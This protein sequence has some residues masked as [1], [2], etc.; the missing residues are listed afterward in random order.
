MNKPF[1]TLREAAEMWGYSEEYFQRIWPSLREK[2][3]IQ[4]FKPGRKILFKTKEIER[5][6]ESTAVN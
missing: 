1:I 3:D 4:A 2:F 6:I 5:A